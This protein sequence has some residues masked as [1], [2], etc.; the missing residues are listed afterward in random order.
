MEM[1][2]PLVNANKLATLGIPALLAITTLTS[3][4]AFAN[5]IGGFDCHG[6]TDCVDGW[7]IAMGQAT[8]DYNYNHGYNYYVYHWQ[9]YCLPYHSYDYCSGYW[10]SYNYEWNTI[11]QQQNQQS[12]QQSNQEINIYNYGNGN[13]FNTG[14]STS[15]GSDQGQNQSP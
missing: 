14:Q 3:Q 5:N 1:K 13:T 15:Q 10:H 4:F 2:E 6:E 7:N 11:A 8:Q 12:N 9:Q